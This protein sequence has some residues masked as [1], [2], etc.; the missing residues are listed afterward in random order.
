M[1]SLDNAGVSATQA[2]TPA[3]ANQALK[4]HFERA[5]ELLQARATVLADIKAWRAEARGEGLDPIALLR[6][7]R[8][9]LLDADQRRKAAERAEVEDLA[10]GAP[11]PAKKP[12]S[13]WRSGWRRAIQESIGR[14]RH[15]APAG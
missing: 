2:T 10:L 12:M 3:T 4:A 5:V 7:A 1:Q 11:K 13:W 15:C 14:M 6:L 8:E 9:H